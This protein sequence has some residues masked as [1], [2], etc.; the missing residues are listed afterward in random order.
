[1]HMYDVTLV[2]GGTVSKGTLLGYVGATGDVEGAH[3]HMEV[4]S[5]ASRPT[6]PKAPSPEAV[7][8]P[9]DFYRY[10]VDFTGD[11]Y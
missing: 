5:S 3:L 8:T 11:P 10:S 2:K 9:Y 6:S 1:M 7:I 4:Y